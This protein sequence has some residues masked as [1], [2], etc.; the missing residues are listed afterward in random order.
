MPKYQIVT[1]GQLE[2]FNR[3]T[4]LETLFPLKLDGVGP[5]CI[6]RCDVDYASS[7]KDRPRPPYLDS[8]VNVFT[9]GAS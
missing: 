8:T 7:C 1:Q 6:T 4:T 2:N 9:V 3:V 5:W